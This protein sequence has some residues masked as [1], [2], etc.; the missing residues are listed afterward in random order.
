[1]TEHER[2]IFHLKKRIETTMI[3]ALSKFENNFGFLWGQNIENEEQLTRE[4]IEFSDIWE[5]TRNQILNQGNAQI[6]NLEDDFYKYGGFFKQ[7]FNYSFR[8]PKDNT[9]N[10]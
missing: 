10:N 2:L 8:V 9:K 6:R 5:R 7:N 1:M 3:G 4:Q